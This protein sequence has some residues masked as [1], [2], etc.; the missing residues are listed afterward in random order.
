MSLA[1][2][3]LAALHKSLD[4][5]DTSEPEAYIISHMTICDLALEPVDAISVAIDVRRSWIIESSLTIALTT[6][7][8]I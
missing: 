1:S 8:R 4:G 5:W 2:L 3:M 7:P 6:K